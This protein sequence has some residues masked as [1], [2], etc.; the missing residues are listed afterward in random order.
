MVTVIIKVIVEEKGTKEV[1]IGGIF[2]LERKA[3]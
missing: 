3:R 1:S 2:E